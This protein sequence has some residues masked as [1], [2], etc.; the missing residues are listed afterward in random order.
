[1]T[2][3]LPPFP[4]GIDDAPRASWWHRW[5]DLGRT[6]ARLDPDGPLYTVEYGGDHL[7]PDVSPERPED[8]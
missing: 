6:A 5:A 2:P 8:A 3:Q 7:L 4:E 1:M